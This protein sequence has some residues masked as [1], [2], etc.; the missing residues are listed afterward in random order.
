MMSSPTAALMGATSDLLEGRS[1]KIALGPKNGT[2]AKT[3]TPDKAPR[4]H[5]LDQPLAHKSPRERLD[6]SHS[7]KR[8]KISA[9]DH[10]HWPGWA[11]A[12][13]PTSRGLPFRLLRAGQQSNL[14]L[15][16]IRDEPLLLVVALP[17]PASR[18]LLRCF[19]LV[20]DGQNIELHCN[21]DFPRYLFGVLE[22]EQEAGNSFQRPTH[23]EFLMETD[24][25]AATR[26]RNSSSPSLKITDVIVMPKAGKF[27]RYWASPWR[28]VL[29]RLL[30]RALP[31]SPADF[32]YSHL[33]G[34]KYLLIDGG[35][36]NDLTA[37]R[38]RTAAHHLYAKGRHQKKQPVF[39][40]DREPNPGTLRALIEWMETELGESHALTDALL[41]SFNRLQE[42]AQAQP[43]GTTPETSARKEVASAS[44]DSLLRKANQLLNGRQYAAALDAYRDFLEHCPE[45]IHTLWPS[46]LLARQKH[47]ALRRGSSRRTYADWCACFDYLPRSVLQRMRQ[48]SLTWKN[49]PLIS[50][51]MPVYAPNL[52]WLEQAIDSVKDQAYTNWELCIADDASPNLETRDFLR[53]CAA[54]DRRVRLVLREE[55]GHIPAATNSALA[56]ARGDYV[57]LMDQDDLLAP[58]ALFRI[59]QAIRENPGAGLIYSD[60]DHIDEHGTRL[61]AYFKAE[62]D[63]FLMRGHNMVT[64][65]GVYRTD[66]VRKL[67]GM[68][69]GLEGAQD[70]DLALRCTEQLQPNQIT[71]VKDRPGHDRR[72]AIDASKIERELGWRPT[73]TFETGIRK[74]VQWYLDNQDW[75]Q[76]VTSGAY[77][78]WVE[79]QYVS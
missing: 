42:R 72:Y 73:E 29:S 32:P 6:L 51:L 37:R 39:A 61:H 14:S 15:S 64:H 35:A 11:P 21:P 78:E 49:A 59:A 48:E 76:N 28:R 3:H 33:D 8:I 13:T 16:L 62:F 74:T 20:G 71:F 68:R 1:D 12:V 77:R 27:S 26:E 34:L 50:I 66:L 36:R 45:A 19:R 54:E 40:V 9:T 5:A 46:M 43:N 31:W 4:P 65:L 2:T 17:K 44:A 7:P 41:G 56:L 55:N 47:R 58:H 57:A 38:H 60:E 69:E 22:P 70:W 75:V 25:G 24:S 67:G 10:H 63:P 23:L 79:K 18:A 52:D 30:N 53:R